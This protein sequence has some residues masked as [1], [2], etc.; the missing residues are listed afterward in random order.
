MQCHWK[1][2]ANLVAA[3]HELVKAVERSM[4]E[5]QENEDQ[6]IQG[7]ISICISLC[8]NWVAHAGLGW[9]KDGRLDFLSL[10]VTL[11]ESTE[12]VLELLS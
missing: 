3:H 9:I 10:S 12:G 6:C 2:V 11:A 8:C 7:A 4:G 1:F 5:N